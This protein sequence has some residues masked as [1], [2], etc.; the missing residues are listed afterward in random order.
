MTSDGYIALNTVS[1]IIGIALVFWGLQI[2][3]VYIIFLG[4]VLGGLLSTA[5]GSL[6]GLAPAAAVFAAIAGV[7]LGGLLAW[8][9]QKFYLFV[10]VGTVFGLL[11]AAAMAA[12]H[13][14]PEL[15]LIV[16]TALFA[17]S[18]AISVLLFKHVVIILMAFAGAHRI[19][20]LLFHPYGFHFADGQG[21]VWRRMLGVVIGPYPSPKEA[22][23]NSVSSS[24]GEFYSP[25]A[26]ALAFI[27]LVCICF[28][29]YFQRTLELKH[30]IGD[31]RTRV[32]R[33]RR[34]AYLVSLLAVAAYP[35]SQPLNHPF[36]G[37]TLLGVDAASWPLV[38]LAVGLFSNWLVPRGHGPHGLRSLGICRLLAMLVFGVSVVPLITWG[39]WCVLL[40]RVVPSWYYEAFFVNDPVWLVIKW[41]CAPVVLAG[42]VYL[43]VLHGPEGPR[44]ELGVGMVQYATLLPSGT[45]SAGRHPMCHV[46]RNLAAPERTWWSDTMA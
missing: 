15:C 38:A 9:L 35:L 16:G 32:I 27:A 43:A 19:F 42:L 20:S 29:W 25:H 4:L 31:W 3:R 40:T 28:A 30:A 24:I 5:I 44:A 13:V 12:M 45:P 46:P 11:A 23:W 10:A 6:V 37:S 21:Q 41:V 36:E 8:P 17:V 26:V 22:N 33:S 14:P 39:V 2:Y 1:L 7:L 34:A 18:G